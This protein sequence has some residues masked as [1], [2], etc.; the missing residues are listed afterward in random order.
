MDIKNILPNP[1]LIKPLDFKYFEIPEKKEFPIYPD[2][3]QI[4]L[5]ETDAQYFKSNFI[6]SNIKLDTFENDEI[7]LEKRYLIS[8]LKSSAG[9]NPQL[10]ITNIDN[11]HKEELMIRQKIMDEKKELNERKK[12][13]LIKKIKYKNMG[14]RKTNVIYLSKAHH[15]KASEDN[16]IRKAKIYFINSALRYINNQYKIYQE[17][18]LDKKCHKKLV[19]KIKPN[20]TKYLKKIDE[21]KFL[22]KKISEILKGK[23]SNKCSKHESNY[24]KI[25]IEKLM[26]EN[27]LSEIIKFL[28]K[29]VKDAYEIYIGKNSL[30]DDFNIKD[31]LK[32]IEKKN[33]KEYAELYKNIAMELILKIKKKGRKE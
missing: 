3:N 7:Y 20:F 9:I 28:N 1:C 15:G 23:V 4:F 12:I 22:S 29:T 5:E 25:Q 16:I 11:N 14:R 33:G 21:Q 17:K 27:E 18:K 10:N 6:K 8:D 31:D 13:F 19:Q 30:I 24:N 2:R 26:K 32:K